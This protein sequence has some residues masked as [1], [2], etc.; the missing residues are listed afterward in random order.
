MNEPVERDGFPSFAKEGWLRHKENGPVPYSAQT[1]WL[2]Q[3][4]DYPN[5]AGVDQR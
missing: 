4:T 1:G 2:F 5:P 3:A